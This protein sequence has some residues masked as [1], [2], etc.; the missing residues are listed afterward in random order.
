MPNVYLAAGLR[1]AAMVSFFW[2]STAPVAAQGFPGRP[3]DQ[4]R[5]FG[6]S[7]RGLMELDESTSSLPS[8]WEHAASGPATVSSDVLRHPLTASARKRLQKAM[9]LAEL[10]K[11]PA[12]IQE[13]RETLLQVP[14]SA[15]YAQNLLGVE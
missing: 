7:P 6:Y 15:P 1:A 10:G 5:T 9:H 2:M 13:L 14:S 12:A 8:S 4:S 3:Y 11:H